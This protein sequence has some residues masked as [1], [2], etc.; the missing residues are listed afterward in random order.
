MTKRDYELIAS[1]LRNAILPT[2]DRRRL[3]RAFGERLNTTNPRFDYL[4][5]MRASDPELKP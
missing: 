5:F 2:D 1:V 3:I 4:R